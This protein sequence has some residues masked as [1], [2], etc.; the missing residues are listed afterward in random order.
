MSFALLPDAFGTT[1]SDDI[2]NYGQMSNLIKSN[3]TLNERLWTLRPPL[4]NINSSLSQ[5]YDPSSWWYYTGNT[6]VNGEWIEQAGHSSCLPS[7]TYQWGFSSLMLF[8]FSIITIMFA[9]VMAA[10]HWNTEWHSRASHYKQHIS[11][12][13]DALDLSSELRLQLGDENVEEMSAKEIDELVKKRRGAVRLDVDK[14]APSRSEQ[15]RSRSRKDSAALGRSG[16]QLIERLS[17]SL[18]GIMK[19]PTV[20][21]EE[22][23]LRP[24]SSKQPVFEGT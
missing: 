11:I 22:I 15:R 5:S 8:T 6:T 24:T 7:D 23:A 10:L 20:G 21:E 4:L 13:R 14:L 18:P 1:H 17:T 3:I 19:G 16:Y 2:F 9:C 12:Y